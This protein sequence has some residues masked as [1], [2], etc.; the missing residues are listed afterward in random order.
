MLQPRASDLL[1]RSRTADASFSDAVGWQTVDRNGSGISVLKLQIQGLYV[2]KSSIEECRHKP[3][4]R[5]RHSA[6]E[7]HHRAV[8]IVLCEA[9]WTDFRQGLVC[10]Q[11][12]FWILDVQ[13]IRTENKK[14]D[15]LALQ[16]G[17]LCRCQL[18]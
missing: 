12:G 7:R 17:K 4:R 1:G 15:N 2:G 5:G 14:R 11:V 10:D 8:L 18:P 16:L 3:S 6:T 13:E 9:V